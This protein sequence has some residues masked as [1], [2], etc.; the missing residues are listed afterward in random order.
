MSSDQFVFSTKN[1]ILHQHASFVH[2]S[3]AYP[4]SAKT[5]NQCRLTPLSCWTATFTVKSSVSPHAHFFTLVLTPSYVSCIIFINT[6]KT[7]PFQTVNRKRLYFILFLCVVRNNRSNE[8]TFYD[9]FFLRFINMTIT[10]NFLNFQSYI[11]QT[12]LRTSCVTC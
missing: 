11:T 1:H 3:C 9:T 4:L 2:F 6:V 5:N 12:L 10:V 7:S 8:Q